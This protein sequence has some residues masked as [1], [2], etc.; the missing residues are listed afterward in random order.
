MSEFVEPKE[1]FRKKSKSVDQSNKTSN[2]QAKSK[3]KEREQKIMNKRKDLEK[4]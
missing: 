3:K 1:P 4:N 2:N